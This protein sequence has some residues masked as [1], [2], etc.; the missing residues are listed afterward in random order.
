APV[1]SADVGLHA[2]SDIAETINPAADAGTQQTG[3]A[4]TFT[5][6]DLIDRPTASYAFKAIAPTGVTLSSEQEAALKA[7]FSATAAAGN[8]NNG[9]VNWT[10]SIAESSLDFLGKGQSVKL[11]YTITVAD[12]KGGSSSQDVIVTVNGVNDAPVAVADSNIDPNHPDQFTDL[13]KEAGVKDHGNA[14]EAGDSLAKGNVLANDTDVD[15][16]DTKSVSALT[17]SDKILGLFVKEG[18]Y[19]K[20]YLAANGD[21]TYDLR[22]SDAQTNALKQG[23]HVTDTFTYT[24]KDANGLTSQTTLT[25]MIEGTND[26]PV[27]K[28]QYADVGEGIAKTDVSTTDGN[29]LNGATDVDHD[30]VLS[31]A[32]VDGHSDG[33]AGAAGNYGT[34][35]WNAATGAYTYTLDN[36]KDA[37]Q[38]LAKGELRLETFTFTVADEHGAT[39][40]RTL[41]VTITG[42]NDA[43][44][45]QAQVN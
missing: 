30:H 36:T 29:L 38:A 13:V 24:V 4:L 41:T 43:P 1:L 44:V 11:T 8:T 21:Y 23:E 28:A 6:V 42:T 19:G 15:F 20:L 2:V 25:I 27:A 18:I 34:L 16:N 33:A 3:G 32:N 7:A 26:A 40:T 5:D 37:V 22:D 39:S 10:Y 31:V 17:G 14:S 45:A 12:G 9:R 35:T